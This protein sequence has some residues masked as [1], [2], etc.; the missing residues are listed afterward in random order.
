M[1][2]IFG[3]LAKAEA[4]LPRPLLESAIRELFILSETRGKESSGIAVR[5]SADRTLHVTK[6]DIPASELIRSA[7]YRR[8]LDKA[9]GPSYSDG[10]RELAAIAHSRLVTNGSQENNTNNQPCIKDGVVM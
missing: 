6:D 2:G 1:C 5:G 3:I 9:L 10:Q 4:D 8:F 7:E